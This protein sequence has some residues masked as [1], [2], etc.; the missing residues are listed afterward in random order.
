MKIC[1]TCKLEKYSGE[2]NGSANSED[3]LRKSCRICEYFNKR[4]NVL[5]DPDILTDKKYYK[6]LAKSSIVAFAGSIL[7]RAVKSGKLKPMPCEVC[8]STLNVN[9][10]HDDYNYPLN[11]RWLCKSHHGLWHSSNGKG[12]NPYDLK[13]LTIHVLKKDLEIARHE[14][15]KLKSLNTIYECERSNKYE[16]VKISLEP[17]K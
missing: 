11:V 13:M 9:A 16:F 1:N 10:H 17:K 12:K 7:S 2:F 14:I 4:E 8:A 5:V 3:R 15:D 6:S